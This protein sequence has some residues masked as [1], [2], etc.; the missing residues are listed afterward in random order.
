MLRLLL[1][2]TLLLS[3]CAC[4]VENGHSHDKGNELQLV[5]LEKKP[6]FT[7]DNNWLADLPRYSQGYYPEAD[8]VT[9]LAAAMQAASLEN[10][11]IMMIV[12]G[13]WCSWCHVM[14]RFFT[15]NE[16][17][18]DKLLSNFIML[19]VN[20]S[21]ENENDVFLSN[22]PIINGYPHIFMLS[23]KGDLSASVNTAKLESGNSYSI[24]K[25]TELLESY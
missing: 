15:E 20:M 22:Y 16:T 11:M 14:S 4:E 23:A 21:E 7:N 12:G 17:V 8:P 9:D 1:F 2:A 5:R 19:K 6:D 24:V 25:F 18:R 13:D 3:I 10:K